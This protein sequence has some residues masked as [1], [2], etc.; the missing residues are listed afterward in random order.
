MYKYVVERSGLV[1]KCIFEMGSRYIY[2]RRLGETVNKSY[3]RKCE[4]QK[5]PGPLSPRV[6]MLVT[7]S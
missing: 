4:L 2:R 6:A 3:R 7:D 1:N 5:T